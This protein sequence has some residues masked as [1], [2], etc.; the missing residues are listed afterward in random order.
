MKK[1]IISSLG[2]LV[3]VALIISGC[4]KSEEKKAE[5]PAAIK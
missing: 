3:I 5:A 4:S 2:A 1:E